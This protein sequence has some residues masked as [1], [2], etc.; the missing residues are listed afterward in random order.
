VTDQGIFAVSRPWMV[1]L[2]VVVWAVWSFS[3]GL[4]THRLPVDRLDRDAW[5][6]RLRPAELDASFYGRLRVK[7]WK[8]R[9]PEAGTFFAGGFSKRA[10]VARDPV[11]LERFV[12]E[13]RRAEVTHWLV[14]AIAPV[15]VVWNPWW[16]VVIMFVYAFVAN[17]PCLLVQRYNRMRL[18]RVLERQKRATR[19]T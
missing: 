17:A 14:M 13:T 6:L 16:V 11:Y 18:Y 7:R 10:V 8:D 4:F 19:S 3:V 2:D 15:F 9:L 12:I 5:L 1:I